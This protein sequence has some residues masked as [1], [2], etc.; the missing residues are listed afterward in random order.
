MRKLKDLLQVHGVAQ[1]DLAKLLGRDKSVITN[2]LQGK[3]QLKAQEAVIIAE[4][5]NVPVTEVLGEDAPP[6]GMDEPA[7]IPFQQPPANALQKAQNVVKKD[8]T[9]YLQE[10]GT[11]SDKAYAIEVKDDSLNL[12][13]FMPGDIIIS[14][15]DKPYKKGDVVVVQHYTEDM[16]E[17]ILRNYA[18]PYLTAHSSN[19][20][21]T[22]IPVDDTSVRIVSPVIR[23]IRTF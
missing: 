15:L 20:K 6:E 2:L 23:L 3:R 17:S 14:E 5:L 12:S 7:W 10:S 22:S 19:S 8:Q 18:P 21:Y 16:A 13:G 1:T 4:F 11:F 9:F